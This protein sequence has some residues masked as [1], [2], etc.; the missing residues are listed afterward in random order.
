MRLLTGVSLLAIVACSSPDEAA[1]PP[2]PSGDNA[3]EAWNREVTPPSDAE[4]AAARAACDYAA[5]HLPAETHGASERQGAAIP[6]DHVVIVMMENRS[7]DHYFQ[8][9]PEYGQPDV[10]VAPADFT[11][12]DPDGLPV[13]TFRDEGYCFVDTAHGHGSTMAQV[14][15]GAMDGFVVTSEGNHELPVGGTLEMLKGDRA[16]SY[17]D[18]RDIPF[19]YWLANEFSIGD[20]YFSS[21]PGPT[22]PNRVYL[23]AATSFGETSNVLVEAGERPTVLDYLELRGVSWKLYASTTASLGIVVDKLFEFNQLGRIVSVSEYFVDAANGTLPQ[24]A[25]VEPG[26]GREAHDANDEHPPAIMQIGQKFVA[27]VVDALTKS[28]HWSRSA[29]FLTYDEHGGLYDHVAP[30]PACRPDDLAA[31]SGFA[32]DRLGVRVPFIVVSPYARKHHVSHR[33]YD[34]ASIVRFLEARFVMPAMTGRDA[35]AEAPFDM[36]DFDSPAFL[37]PPAIAI[38]PVDANVLASCKAIFEG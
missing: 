20:Q 6:I 1:S 9:L 2:P 16:L 22:W 12:P 15:D 38:P 13:G 10:E 25:F 4:A 7:F 23:Y 27:E 26:I 3:P 34:H 5:G 11:N 24:V 14:N 8:K 29:L 37:D 36:F 28:P 35:N 33:V 21:I 31:E 30:P 17:Y 18:E 19:Y 32:F